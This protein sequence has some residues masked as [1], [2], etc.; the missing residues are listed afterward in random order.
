MK[1]SAVETFRDYKYRVEL[2]EKLKSVIVESKGKLYDSLNKDLGKSMFEAH[3]SEVGYV[4]DEID[5]TLKN[6]K[7]WMSP[8]KVSTPIKL[9]PGR[10]YIQFE[11]Y[12][13]VL[14]LAAWNY[15]FMVLFS[16]LVAALAAGNSAVLKPSEVSQNT[17]KVIFEMISKNFD[18]SDIQVKTGGPQA[19]QDLLKEKW[20]FIFFT[21]STVVGKIIM[22]AAAENLTPVCLELGGKS[23]CVVEDDANI[24]IAAKRIAWGKFFNAGQTC[25]APDYLLVHEKIYDQFI[26]LLKEKTLKYYQNG[27]AEDYGKIINNRHL[28]RLEALLQNADVIIGGKVDLGKCQ[29]QPTIIKGDWSHPSMKEEIFGPILPVFKFQ[30]SSEAI[31]AIQSLDKPLSAYFFTESEEK[32]SRY[33]SEISFGG[34]CI[35]DC[36]LHL[37]SSE[38]PF[39]GV[40]ASGIGAYHGQRGFETLSHQKSILHKSSRIDPDLRYPPYKDTLKGIARFLFK[41]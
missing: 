34:G 13:R 31:T 29:I 5:H 33:L 2:L 19:T 26:N 25:V 17:E 24:E 38:L 32:A 22:K 4:L 21:G 36:L 16:P 15:P 14:I 30:K 10:S 1:K 35:N 39:G 40:G 20:D 28:Q 9:L 8:K 6:L 18:P 23:P 27:A 12:G 3:G 7:S 41:N 11:P 37:G